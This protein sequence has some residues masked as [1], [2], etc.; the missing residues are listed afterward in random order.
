ME[1]VQ[2]KIKIK[3]LCEFG[4]SV[5]LDNISRLIID[6]GELSRLIDLG[7]SGVTSNPTIF[8]QAVSGSSDY[9]NKIREFKNKG[10]SAFEVYDELTVKDIQDAADLF[11]PVF[12]K[13]K[14][15]NGYV[16]LEVN[17][18]L[19][20]KTEETI[21]EAQRL[22]V[23]VDRLNVMFKVPATDMGLEAGR[24]L[25]AGGIN[26]NFTLIFSLGQYIKTAETFVR[27]AAEFLKSGGDLK[28][29]HSV[30]SIF[31]S[32]IDTS[33]DKLI[34][35]NLIS[36]KGQVDK[37]ILENLKGRAAVA[38]SRLIFVKY[39]DIFSREDFKKLEA[40]G[41]Y[42]QRV[43]WASTST[44]N[45]AYSDLKYVTELI[46][47]ATINTMPKATMDAFIDH[48]I[49]KNSLSQDIGGA[50]EVIGVLK[51]FGIDIDKVCAGL[52]RDGV[53]A[54]EK[55]FNSLLKTIEF[56]EGRL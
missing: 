5:W 10:L 3:E 38:N 41:L 46:G 52:L 30:A 27:A 32:R 14:G 40:N 33:V 17:P 9:D 7:V 28:N 20:H 56:K 44:K 4:Q 12:K 36:R 37:S 55:S 43:L 22:H 19:A 45:P 2:T 16:S 24:R 29:I 11:Q 48:G 8:D 13:T 50:Q 1:S 6:N 26:I 18:L 23:K 47:K 21:S 49:I 51:D 39:L 25:L 35:Q 42:R 54:F 15:L 31:V 53:A 34:E